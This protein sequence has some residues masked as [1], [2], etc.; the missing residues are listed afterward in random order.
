LKVGRRICPRSHLI[1][2]CVGR[3]GRC[4][5]SWYNYLPKEMTRLI[6]GTETDTLFIG[7]SEPHESKRWGLKSCA[8]TSVLRP[9]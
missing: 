7:R 3:V 5:D 1:E 8:V 6:L 9:D 4:Q 2:T